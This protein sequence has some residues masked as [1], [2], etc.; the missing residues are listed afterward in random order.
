MSVQHEKA[1][2]QACLLEIRKTLETKDEATIASSSIIDMIDKALEPWQSKGGY[3]GGYSRQDGEYGNIYRYP[4][5]REIKL[6][7]GQR[8]AESATA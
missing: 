8:T 6:R 1:A 3:V 4:D 5:G 2:L 7:S